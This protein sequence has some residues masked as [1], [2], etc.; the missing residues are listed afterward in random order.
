MGKW[1]GGDYGDSGVERAQLLNFPYE[2]IRI[3]YEYNGEE[4]LP[5]TP[6]S[7]VI[8]MVDALTLHLEALGPDVAQ[9]TWNR[10]MI[11]YQTLN[12]FSTSGLYDQSGLSMNLFLKARTFLV[13]EKLL[14]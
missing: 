11:I 6:E 10:E 4:A 13:K 7:A 5:S 14:P 1:G 8:H 2:L 12:E 3:I 9:S